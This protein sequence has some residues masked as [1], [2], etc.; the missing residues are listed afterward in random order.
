MYIKYKSIAYYMAFI[1]IGILATISLI[2]IGGD[3]DNTMVLIFT[4]ILGV[5]ILF[6]TVALYNKIEKIIKK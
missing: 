6:N 5:S 4:K 1:L 2:L 3:S